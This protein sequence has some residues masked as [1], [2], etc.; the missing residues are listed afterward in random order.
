MSLVVSDGPS[1]LVGSVYP[2]DA[3]DDLEPVSLEKAVGF[4][5]RQARRSDLVFHYVRDGAPQRVQKMLLASKV[6]DVPC[7]VAWGKGFG[8]FDTQED[9]HVNLGFHMALAVR[10]VVPYENEGAD[11]KI[12]KFVMDPTFFGAIT[13]EKEWGEKLNLTNVELRPEGVPPSWATGS[14]DPDYSIWDVLTKPEFE[15]MLPDVMLRRLGFENPAP[16]M[17]RNV[18][19]SDSFHKLL[20]EDQK[21][22]PSAQSLTACA[23]PKRVVGKQKKITDYRKTYII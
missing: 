6:F 18:F 20:C 15:E 21:I 22:E 13:L 5:N 23:S 17:P 9:K 7:G 11:K 12:E 2:L 10:V 4:F 1:S 3:F 16:L 8:P 14:F 19:K